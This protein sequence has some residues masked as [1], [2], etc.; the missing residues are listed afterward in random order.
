MGCICMT[1]KAKCNRIVDVTRT[2][3]GFRNNM[4]NLYLDSLVSMT[5]T[6]MSCRCH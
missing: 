6:A 2:T 5:N 1:I 4:M 3:F